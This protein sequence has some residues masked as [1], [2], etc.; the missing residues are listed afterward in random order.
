MRRTSLRLF[1]TVIGLAVLLLAGL[2]FLG[3]AV[4][5][6]APARLAQTLPVVQAHL[7]PSPP[8]ARIVSVAPVS[9]PAYQVDM[10]RLGIQPL[11]RPLQSANKPVGGTFGLGLVSPN[12]GAIGIAN[13]FMSI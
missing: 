9:Q 6:G 10:A 13:A 2:A 3:G 8:G 11:A 7:N 5:A 4:G 12:G 1:S